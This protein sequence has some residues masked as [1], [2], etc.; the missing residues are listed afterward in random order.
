[1]ARKKRARA[2]G[3][4]PKKR[5]RQPNSWVD[6]LEPE[7]LV[8]YRQRF[9]LSERR[10]GDYLGVSVPTIRNWTKGGIAPS[11]ERQATIKERLARDYAPPAGVVPPRRGRPPK[12]RPDDSVAAA[13]APPR[14]SLAQSVAD[15]AAAYLR[16]PGG[17][18]LSPDQLLELLSRIT[19]Q[20]S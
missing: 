13:P 3:G 14:G 8:E 19:R 7:Q 10:L 9:G 17:Q 2:E 12:V 16:T 6:G 5:G 11:A 1:M 20:L 15:L 18:N 4:A